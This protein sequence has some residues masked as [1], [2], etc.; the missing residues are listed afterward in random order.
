MKASFKTSWDEKRLYLLAEVEDSSINP[1]DAVDI[2]IDGNNQKTTKIQPEDDLRYTLKRSGKVSGNAIYKVKEIE[3]RYLVEASLPLPAGAALDQ[4]IGFDIR[5]N[6]ADL[7]KKTAWNDFSMSQETDPS[8][9]GTLILVPEMRIA[10]VIKGTPKVDAVMDT[11]W[12]KANVFTTAIKSQDAATGAA[13][14]KG[15][16]AKVRTMWDENFLYV[17]CE[18][19]D[20]VLNKASTAPYEQDSVEIFIDENNGKTTVYEADDAQYRVNYENQQTFGA[21]GAQPNFKSATKLVK[22]GYMIEAAIPLRT[23][24]GKNGMVIGFDA[25]VND[26]NETGKR[27]SVMTWNDPKGN[28]YRDTS[29]FGCLVFV[30]K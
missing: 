29:W 28:N 17:F 27:Q 2:F 1:N 26:A 13:T 6:D 10:N 23:V 11:I 5:V 19:T 14:I 12:S 18:V 24:K 7:D 3:G 9:Y 4:G 16:T 20:P 25:Q 21:N 22:G 8:K 30:L 15:A